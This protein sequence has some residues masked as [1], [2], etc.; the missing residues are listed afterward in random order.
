MEAANQAKID[1]S[2]AKIKG[3]IGAKKREG[4]T[5]Q[6]AAKIDAESKIMSTRRDAEMEQANVELATKKAMWSQSAKMAQVEAD[7]GS[8][9]GNSVWWEGAEYYWW[10]RH[11]QGSVVEGGR[12]EA[13]WYD[14]IRESAARSRARRQ[15]HTCDLE[16]ELQ[17][18][19][20][21]NALLQHALVKS[22]KEDE[23]E[24]DETA[25]GYDK[26]APPLVTQFIAQ[27]KSVVIKLSDAAKQLGKV[28]KAKQYGQRVIFL[29]ILFLREREYYHDN[30]YHRTI[31]KV[32]DNMEIMNLQNLDP[33]KN[34][35]FY[36]SYS[37]VHYNSRPRSEQ[38]LIR[39]ATLHLH[40]IDALAKMVD[41]AL[42]GLYPVKSLSRFA[43]VIA[44]C[45]QRMLLQSPLI[46][47]A[48]RVVEEEGGL[49]EAIKPLKAHEDRLKGQNQ[50]QGGQLLFSTN[51]FL[52]KE[53]NKESVVFKS[54][55]A[56]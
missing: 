38:S 45:A 43:D 28:V 52:K 10:S 20:E 40:D 31:S 36:M 18:L 12:K 51:E 37:P 5:L 49:K 8:T 2:E 41:P 34:H 55:V 26:L 27:A 19:K 11:A 22:D 9:T 13:V 56:W 32:P 25:Q 39:W 29:G 33:E 30:E 21:E 44:L 48:E 50:N 15:A 23:E 42:N 47:L 35:V 46:A 53:N 3:A 17:V 6:N 1:V 16:A 7:K 24:V 14:K 54:E 4:L